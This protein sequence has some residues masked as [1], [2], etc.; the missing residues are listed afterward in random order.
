ML[1]RISIIMVAVICT[2]NLICV[3]ANATT[4]NQVSNTKIIKENEETK[5]ENDK[6]LQEEK[7]RIKE[8]EETKKLEIEKK[9]KALKEGISRKK[10]IKT[11]ILEDKTFK[12]YET[13]AA[14]AEKEPNNTMAQANVLGLNDGNYYVG[15]LVD[16]NSNDSWYTYEDEDYYKVTLPSDGQLTLT[17]SHNQIPGDNI[18]YFKIQVL[19]NQNGEY[20][21]KY[22]KGYDG[23]KE[24]KVGLKK[25]IYYIKIS[26]GSYYGTDLKYN[27]SAKFAT[28]NFE[29]EDNDTMAVATTIS[30]NQIFTGNLI[31][32]YDKD[33]YKLTIPSDG[34]VTLNLTT[35]NI[36]GN[37]TIYYEID[38]LNPKAENVIGYYITGNS[39]G[40]KTKIG[41]KKGT[42][43]IRIM[44]YYYCGDDPYKI[45]Y[46]FTANSDY[47]AENNSAAVNA[48]DLRLNKLKTGSLM[49]SSD[50]DYYKITLSKQ[51]IYK[52]KFKHPMQKD[53][54]RYWD[55]NILDAKNNQYGL[56]YSYGQETDIEKSFNLNPGTYYIK[57]QNYYYSDSEYS[58][59]LYEQNDWK[60][61]WASSQ[62]QDAMNKGWVD[63]ADIFRPED[64]ITRA[65]FVKIVNR[66]FGFK[67]M[68]TNEPYTDVYKSDWYYN[69]VRIAI[70]AGYISTNNKKFRPNDT[71]SREE[72]A[73]IITSI[74][75]NKDN[76]LDKI[77]KYKDY[78]KISDWARTSVE[79]AVEKGYMGKGSD[80][81]RPKSNITRAEAIVTLS[82]VK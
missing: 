62:I 22:S 35:K 67:T 55:I 59:A 24:F 39:G 7:K 42:Y 2:S 11:K 80:M 26:E 63:R 66:A 32:T 72:V 10:E 41:L 23:K 54:K 70:K 19:N 45:S 6:K 27:L 44:D 28:G 52:I 14:K 73:A 77:K 3:Q 68:A 71:I 38:L 61:N 53:N 78:S 33:Y 82:R 36:P 34:E 43:Y 48:N 46:S 81:F 25:G 20:L 18:D 57:V 69:D 13:K 29:K 4:K 12:D 37:N 5:K 64:S 15:K 65:E 56:V 75:K 79:G 58:L 1:K 40:I 17:F 30:N 50:V 16:Y 76:N 8:E 74:K 21:S 49:S 60:N 47:E 31:S 9:K 51:E